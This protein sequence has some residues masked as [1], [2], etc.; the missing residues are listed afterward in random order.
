L[1][2]AVACATSAPAIAQRADDNAVTAAEDAF[3]T[4][5]GQQTIGLY[6]QTDAR[7]FSPQQAGNLRIEG[8]YFDQETLITNACLVRETIMRIGIATQSFSFPSPT[9]IADLRLRLAGDN[10]VVSTQLT[11]GP[12]DGETATIEAQLPVSPQKFG[13]DLCAAY[14]RNFDIDV[15]RDS[16][17]S[18]YSATMSW[19]PTPNVEIIPFGGF[20]V[21]G[22][23]NQM[24]GVYTDGTY[25]L[26]LFSERALGI[27]DN[28]TF[29][30]HQTTAGVITR[31]K[32]GAAW[33]LDAGFF[34]SIERDPRN[35]NPYLVVQGG[36]SVDSVLDTV[37]P[38]HS[39]GTSGELRLARKFVT[40][41]H[42][43]DAELAIRGRSTDRQFGGDQTVD[44]GT[45]NLFDQT[46][47][48]QPPLALGP[49]SHDIVRQIDVGLT[50][51]EQWRGVGSIGVGVLKDNYNRTVQAPEGVNEVSQSA[52]WLVNLRYTVEAGPR[53]LLYGSYVEGIEDSPLAPVSATNRG[54]LPAASRTWQI[55]TGIRLTPLKSLQVLLGVFEIHKPYLTLNDEGA[56]MPI[57]QL[58]HRGVESSVSFSQDGL[59]IVAG[60]VLL[61]ARAERTL[62]DGPSA[63]VPL[64]PVPLT[65]TGNVDYA[66]TRWRGLAA[67][68]QVTR[69]S[70]RDATNDGSSR[71]PPLTTVSPAVRYEHKTGSHPWTLRF[72]TFNVT[73]ARGLHVSSV[74]QVLPEDRRRYML[75]LAVDY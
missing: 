27:Q 37:P 7:G 8:L 67:S 26:P 33:R 31:A 58:R 34:R 64:G 35:V 42:A 68:L 15:A 54:E 62:T 57:G 6:S 41:V 60:G 51:Q 9:G 24:P 10:R 20:I 46:R 30:W 36:Q 47:F 17:G 25:P 53:A 21:G 23:K 18:I 72:D 40:S 48:P 45:I 73:D 5:V 22:E 14:Y 43:I 29:G 4:Q 2:L 44:F 49:V 70:P 61:Q 50:L 75:T 32:L 39:T 19:R 65:L 52:P 63:Q 56:Y 66:P 71:L 3:G 16:H 11:R 74:G 69:L 12:F 38:S 55:D 1:L 59:T 13:V 28:T